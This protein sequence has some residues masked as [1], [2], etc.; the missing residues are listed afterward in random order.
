MRQLSANCPTLVI[1]GWNRGLI[2]IQLCWNLPTHTLET[3]G[4]DL[5]S[6]S[7]LVRWMPNVGGHLMR[8]SIWPDKRVIGKRVQHN[9]RTYWMFRT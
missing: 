5:S 4:P 2:F 1:Y 6:T 9:M 3:D 8:N 7:A